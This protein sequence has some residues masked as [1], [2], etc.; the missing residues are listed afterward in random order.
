[1]TTIKIDTVK[2]LSKFARLLAANKEE[3]IKP[4]S[5]LDRLKEK[6]EDYLYDIDVTYDLNNLN[7]RTLMN[8]ASGRF[9]S[10]FFAT[11]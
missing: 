3:N 6:P 5:K 7:Y 11:A 4:G 8:I 10:S 2:H 1:M 9:T